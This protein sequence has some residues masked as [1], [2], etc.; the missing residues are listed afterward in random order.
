MFT[1]LTQIS[2]DNDDFD[3][4]DDDDGDADGGNND[5]DEMSLTRISEQPQSCKQLMMMMRSA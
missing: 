5:D 3:N 2:N 1:E 4:K